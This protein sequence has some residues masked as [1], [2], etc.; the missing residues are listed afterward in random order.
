[1]ACEV[2]SD[3]SI[4]T[5]PQARVIGLCATAKVGFVRSSQVVC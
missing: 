5:S 4:K 1:L 2:A 3:E